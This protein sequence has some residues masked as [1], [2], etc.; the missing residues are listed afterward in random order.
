MSSDPLVRANAVACGWNHR[1]W[2]MCLGRGACFVAASLTCRPNLYETGVAIFA[3]RVIPARRS[4][5]WSSCHEGD[6]GARAERVVL[7]VRP[8][9]GPRRQSRVPA[10]ARARRAG[11][12]RG[13]VPARNQ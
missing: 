9:P 2:I 12:I 1:E 5:C 10:S 8:R 11:R 13:R 4:L 3:S 7:G 6:L